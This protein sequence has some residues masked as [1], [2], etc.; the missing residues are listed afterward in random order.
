[1]NKQEFFAR[2]IQ[3]K[4]LKKKNKKKKQK[5]KTTIRVE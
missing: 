1:M 2:M 4:K 5:Q 3:N